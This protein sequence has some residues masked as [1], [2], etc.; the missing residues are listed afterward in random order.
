LLIYYIL[1]IKINIKKFTVADKV[2]VDDVNKHREL[3]SEK[4][5]VRTATAYG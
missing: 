1:I 4:N 5:P 2:V 3:E